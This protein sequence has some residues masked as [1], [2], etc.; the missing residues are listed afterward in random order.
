MVVDLAEHSE[1]APERLVEPLRALEA[2]VPPELVRLALWV[3]DAYCSTPAR[4]LGLVLPPGAGRLKAKEALV[5]S[6]TD[7]GAAALEGEERLTEA[8]RALLER[9]AREGPLTAAVAGHARAR[10]PGAPRPGLARAPRPAPPAGARRGGRARRRRRAAPDRRP[11]GRRGRDRGGCA[12]RPAAAARRHRLGQDRG[13]PAGRGGGAR[14]R[15]G[16]DRARARDRAHA[17][18]RRALRA[19]LRRPR[20]GAALPARPGRAPRRV[21]APAPRRGAHLRRPALGRLRADRRARADRGRRGARLL[22]QA[23]GRPALRRADGRRAARAGLRRG[24][25][26]RQRDAAPRDRARLP[27]HRAAPARGRRLAPARG[28][29]R[30]ARPRGAAAPRHARGA[31]GDPA[32]RRQG[33]RAAQPARLVELPDLP[34]LWAR[35]GVPALRRGA[36]PAPRGRCPGL[37][38][39]R[40]SRARARALRGLRLDRRGPSRGGDRAAGARA[41]GGAGR[42]VVPGVP[43]RLRHRG[44]Q[45][46]P[47]AS[48]WPPSRRRPRGSWSGRRWSPRATTSPT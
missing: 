40:P 23:G 47:R 33:D 39:L 21:A 13:L 17:P 48:A 37:P 27:A 9:L 44:G 41:G 28:G 2:G 15:A 14:A 8:Q 31:G 35:V 12:R 18:D 45:G 10:G 30:H 11:G 20:R 34:R 4:A 29:A 19:P 43:A 1:V 5:A 42:S 46:A 22:L 32:H 16:R 6:L 26:R 25:G 38:S 24:A 36:G 7:A 3:A